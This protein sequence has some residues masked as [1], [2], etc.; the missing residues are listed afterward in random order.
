M[1]KMAFLSIAI[2]FF[3]SI[4]IPTASAQVPE[5]KDNYII[6]FNH[7]ID[8]N[9]ITSYNGTI[10]DRIDNIHAVAAK[11][12]PG[13]VEQLQYNNEIKHIEKDAVAK[14]EGQV[15]DANLANLKVYPDQSP[16]YTG[17]GV[18]V[19]VL[20]TGININHPD[21][22]IAGGVSFVSY[23]TSL[24]DDNGHGTH[25]AGI[26]AA[27]NNDFGIVGVAP[28]VSLYSVKVLDSKGEGNYSDI[29]KGIEWCLQNKINIINLSLA[30]TEGSYALES[31]INKAISQGVIIVAAAGNYEDTSVT[32]KPVEYPAKYS[33][34]I[35]VSAVDVNENIA[36]F[37]ARG[38]EIDL[39]APGVEVTSTYLSNSYAIDSGTSMAAPFVTGIL[40]LYEEA[41]PT[42]TNSDIQTMIEKQALDI[43]AQGVDPLY[44]YGMVQAPA[45]PSIS[46]IFSDI[47][48]TAW[49]G[50]F[51]LDLY[52]AKLTSGY[53]GGVYH[54]ASNITRAEA[55][56]I[57]G[58]AL[59]LDG[60]RRATMFTDVT[61][62]D[63][64]SGYIQ[65]AVEKHLISGYPDQT[66]RPNA[67]LTRGELVSLLSRA[68]QVSGTETQQF[69]DVTP[70]LY[71]YNP[72]MTFASAH[73]AN[74]YPDGTFRPSQPVTRAEFAVFLSRT[75][76]ESS[77]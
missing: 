26:I 24:D 16:L 28:D 35:A 76:D 71:C 70:S 38:P 39:A 18:K 4:I 75:M 19:A 52:N 36:D 17:K 61:E 69:S 45:P 15:I 66:F 74:G 32:E 59:G 60:T 64:Y 54:P 7:A 51:V 46:D 20:D 48:P 13:A 11:L 27:Q 47:S 43:G 73:I 72:I 56:T 63:S 41:Y 29:I 14:V 57:L 30:S 3:I 40:A 2:I 1:R 5:P 50:S 44:G 23:T 77:K 8:T 53:P 12:T 6:V 31:E 21:L 65:S 34:V 42:K 22:K 10:Y 68:Y 58:R 33:G 9:L 37:S 49:Y 62:Q 25:V 55:A 67:L